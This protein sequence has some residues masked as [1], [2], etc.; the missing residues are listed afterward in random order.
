MNLCQR[1]RGCHINI[2]LLLVLVDILFSQ[3]ELLGY[4]LEGLMRNINYL[5]FGPAVQKERSFLVFFIA[6]SCGHKWAL[7]EKPN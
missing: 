5:E 6:S 3:V 7:W 1:F 2:F 4:L